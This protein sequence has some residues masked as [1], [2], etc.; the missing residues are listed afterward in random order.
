MNTKRE[1]E[2]K[3]QSR[4]KTTC[5]LDQRVKLFIPPTD[6][7]VGDADKP[8]IHQLVSEWVPGLTLHDV[9]LSCFISQGDSWHLREGRGRNVVF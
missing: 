7:S 5:G 2:I 8:L 3:L 1:T 9:A 4:P 6:L